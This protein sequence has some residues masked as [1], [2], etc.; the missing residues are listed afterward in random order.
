MVSPTGLAAA[1]AVG[2]ADVALRAA[3]GLGR[4]ALLA[5]G[6]DGREIVAV[7]I[8]KRGRSGGDAG[9]FAAIGDREGLDRGARSSAVGAAHDGDEEGCGT[10]DLA[11]SFPVEFDQRTLKFPCGSNSFAEFFREL[12]ALVLAATY[13]GWMRDAAPDDRNASRGPGFKVLLR[14]LPM[15]WPKDEPQLR[16]RVVSAFLLVLA[17]KAAV[18]VMPFAY[19]AVIDR[20]TGTGVAFALVAGLVLA[21]CGARFAGVLSDNLR[22]AIFE[23]VG[24]HAAR[25]L[26]GRVFRH[27]H[28]L[29][30]RFHLERRTGSLTKIVERGTKSI[31]MML[32]FLLFNIAPTIIELTAICIIFFVKFG[33][34]LVAAT[35]A[36]VAI[37][38]A[39]TR[40]VTDWRAQI[41]RDVRARVGSLPGVTHVTLDWTEMT[42]DEKSGAMAKARWNVSQRPED[43]ALAPTTKV[44]LVASGKGGVGKSSVTVNLAGKG[45]RTA[46][47]NPAV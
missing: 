24:Q 31:D 39:F 3:R 12:F 25:R 9:R 11:C 20:M 32:Y 4:G 21:Y 6:N 43:T 40:R 15:L 23:K 35:L 29:S 46:I 34:G 42:Q 37:Y 2:N 30:L 45:A 13:L 18:L 22:N 28:D 8:V 10:H 38:I 5:L 27:I 41:Q 7:A 17:G 44:V 36:M 16:V 26:A 14:F 1:A 19:K 33:A 47:T